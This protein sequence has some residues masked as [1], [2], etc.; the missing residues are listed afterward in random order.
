[1]KV[2][3]FELK[4]QENGS[5]NKSGKQRNSLHFSASFLHGA[6]RPQGAAEAQ[7][8]RS[9]GAAPLPKK[10]QKLKAMGRCTLKAQRRRSANDDFCRISD[11]KLGFQTSYLSLQTSPNTTQLTPRSKLPSLYIQIIIQPISYPNPPSTINFHLH[12]TTLTSVTT[13]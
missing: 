13:S 1:M 10:W 8:R 12:S 9:G 5:R 4:D 6:L 7:R 2:W 11:A 3:G